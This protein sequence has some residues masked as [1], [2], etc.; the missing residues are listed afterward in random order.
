MQEDIKSYI[1]QRDTMVEQRIKLWIVT[2]L[3]TQ[4]ALLLPIIFFLGGIYNSANAS[5][6]LLNEQKALS[7]GSMRRLEQ[8]EVRQRELRA[9]AVTQGFKPFTQDMPEK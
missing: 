9:W 7:D 5:I 1:D 3:L 2:S 4:I 8:L 6:Q